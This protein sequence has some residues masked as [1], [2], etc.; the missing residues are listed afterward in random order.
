MGLVAAKCTQCGA[1][2]EV[3]ASKE[4][5]ICAHCGTAFITEKVINNYTIHNHNTVNNNIAN[6][7]INVKKGDDIEDYLRRYRAFAKQKKY[8]SAVKLLD[9]M[10]EKFPDSGLTKY[11]QADFVLRLKGYA[12]WMDLVAQGAKDEILDDG[13]RALDANTYFDK[14]ADY[15]LDEMN[16]AFDIM[17]GKSDDEICELVKQKRRNSKNQG[18]AEIRAQLILET[19][20]PD[21][22]FYALG[23][24]SYFNLFELTK[25]YYAK[26]V[27]DLVG[28]HGELACAKKLLT[29]ADDLTSGSERELYAEFIGEVNARVENFEKTNVRLNS[30]MRRIYLLE[31][32]IAAEDWRYNKKRKLR[33]KL[34]SLA[35]K[36]I[37][38]AAVAVGVYLLIKKCML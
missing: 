38:A 34:K 5:G 17:D 33:H 24:D 3:D 37:I 2:I 23:G 31:E 19:V 21:K 36:L 29:L 20:F 32:R 27:D 4:A 1:N 18:N 22:S 14:Y 7:T 13:S 6:A 8:N 35:I 28:G 10:D 16:K 12:G 11:C 30:N 25:I 26:S 15:D 9:K